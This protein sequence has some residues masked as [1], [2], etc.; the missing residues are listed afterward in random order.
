MPDVETG[1]FSED[2][3]AGSSTE[4]GAAKQKVAS[5]SAEISEPAIEQAR[6]GIGKPTRKVVRAKIADN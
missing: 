5:G 6:Y 4:G 1:G 2:Y 3:V